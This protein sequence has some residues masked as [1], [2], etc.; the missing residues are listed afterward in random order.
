MVTVGVD[1]TATFH[2]KDPGPW[3]VIEAV[4]TIV[5]D[6]LAAFP[7]TSRVGI[8][9][10]VALNA[11]EAGQAFAD[12]NVLNGVLSLGQAATFGAGSLVLG[13][14]TRVAGGVSGLGPGA[15]LGTAA[16]I[17]G[18]VLATAG[19]PAAGLDVGGAAFTLGE[20]PGAMTLDLQHALSAAG[21]FTSFGAQVAQGH[22]TDGLLNSLGPW[23]ASLAAENYAKGNLPSFSTGGSS[24]RP[25]ANGKIQDYAGTL[26]ANDQTAS[27]SSAEAVAGSGYIRIAPASQ[28]VTSTLDFLQSVAGRVFQ[29]IEGSVSPQ[30]AS[31]QIASI[32]FESGPTNVGQ[33]GSTILPEG[34]ELAF[35][36]QDMAADI[37]TR[38]NAGPLTVS[39][40]G[41]LLDAD[42]QVAGVRVQI[43]ADAMAG[44]STI[45]TFDGQSISHI[46]DSGFHIQSDFL[47]TV[48]Q[49][50]PDNAEG[51]TPPP[52]VSP[53]GQ[54]ITPTGP[55]P[56]GPDGNDH[57]K[58]IASRS[59]M[60]LRPPTLA[61]G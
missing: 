46:S 5:A 21:A 32:M 35:K 24:T 56:E 37:L 50:N 33:S 52:P 42:G 22:L 9:L 14:A 58:A 8:P 49:N 54:A 31:L 51:K 18:G 16:G 27:A 3:G 55:G 26:T 57:A 12:G 2:D 19:G 53:S 61:I 60:Q 1:G 48:V 29:V 11:A 13:V 34:T 47:D 41:F 59:R 20:G 6:F 25:D 17:I 4:A 15:P 38:T 39:G 30:R 7:P 28:T 10:A 40:N 23:L 43:A 45:K 36:Q 44:T